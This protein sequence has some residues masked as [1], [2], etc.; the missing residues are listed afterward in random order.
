M[1]ENKKEE[2]VKDKELARQME[3]LKKQL[4]ELYEAYMKQFDEMYGDLSKK[5]YGGVVEG[6]SIGGSYINEDGTI[7]V[8]ERIQK[9][10]RQN[11][12]Y[13]VKYQ[14]LLV[15]LLVM[16]VF[17]LFGF[18][19]AKSFYTSKENGGSSKAKV[20]KEKVV[21]LN[22]FYLTLPNKFKYRLKDN[23]LSVTDDSK[24]KA[25]IGILNKDFETLISSKVDLQK[26]IDKSLSS[27]GTKVTDFAEVKIQNINFLLIEITDVN[28]KKSLIIFNEA[29]EENTYV[30][31]LSISGGETDRDYLHKLISLYKSGIKQMEYDIN[32]DNTTLVMDNYNIKDVINNIIESR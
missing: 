24:W 30:T 32:V 18:M 22:N 6:D 8:D 13:L 16:V 21:K 12:N 4:P 14:T 1:E 19:M 17:F 5:A 23:I 31:L 27:I 2:Q 20:L 25:E 9:R 29:S 28:K 26:G 11:K 10:N 3:E 7:N 15:A